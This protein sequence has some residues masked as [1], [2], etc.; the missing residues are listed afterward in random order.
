MLAEAER[1]EPS[2]F[3]NNGLVVAALQAS[4]SA[5]TS[6][7]SLRDALVAAVRAGNDTD[8]VAAITGALAGAYY[9]GSAVPFAWRR[10][11]HGWPGLRG[12]DLVRLGVLTARGGHEDPQGWPSCE[13]L[14]SYSGASGTR[15]PAQN[16]SSLHWYFGRH[17]VWLRR[18][19]GR[20]K[21][22]G[23]VAAR[24]DCSC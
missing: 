5:L 17:R 6:T 10:R 14:A 2:S 12:R 19:R 18:P 1:G 16:P 22:I 3:R 13:R 7:S 11:L 21:G 9:G 20:R 24:R 15:L 4:W 23:T 8:T